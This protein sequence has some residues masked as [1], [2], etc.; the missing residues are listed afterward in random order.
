MKKALLGICALMLVFTTFI[1]SVANPPVRGDTMSVEA[2][3]KKWGAVAFESGAFRSGSIK[4]RA[5]MAASL[6]I[7]KRRS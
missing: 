7:K 4:I 1:Y 2:A 3:T 5:S 6:L